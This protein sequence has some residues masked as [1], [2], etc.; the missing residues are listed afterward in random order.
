ME[1]CHSIFLKQFVHSLSCHVPLKKVVV[2]C[3]AWC[4]L[5][6]LMFWSPD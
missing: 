2:L 1:K 6:G 5:Q 3:D 4:V